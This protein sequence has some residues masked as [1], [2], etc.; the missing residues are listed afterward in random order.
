MAVQREDGFYW[1]NIPG[2]DSLD[3]TTD[4]GGE[5]FNITNVTV[6]RKANAIRSPVETGY[7]VFDNKVIMP[8]E[9]TMSAL[10]KASDWAG[11]WSILQGIYDERSYNFYTVYT[12]GEILRNLMLTEITREETTDKFDA[13]DL[14]LHF[15]QVMIASESSRMLASEN[16]NEISNP[17]DKKDSSTKHTGQKTLVDR[18]IGATAGFF[19]SG[20]LGAIKGAM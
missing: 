2:L 19:T 9:V 5:K 3:G 10:V 4:S 12:R 6:N 8:I 7:Q 1:V 15:V 16:S 14:T 18:Y 11:V 17:S 20:I 13:V